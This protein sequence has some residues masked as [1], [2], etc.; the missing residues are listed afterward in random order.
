VPAE[1]IAGYLKLPVFA[2]VAARLA[3]LLMW[4]PVL[5]AMAIPAR[6]RAL[7]ILGL[8]AMITPL[9]HLPA[10]APDTPLGVLLALG[11]E[12]LLGGLLGLLTAAC[13]VGLEV[14]GQLVAQEAGLAFGQLVDPN[15]EQEQTVVGVFQVQF[16]V[17]VYLVIGGHRALLAACLDTFESIPLLAT[18]A[19]GAAG[20][21][22]LCRVLDQSG[23]V[24]LRVTAP[25]LLALFLV[26]L[27]LGFIS[28]TLP[29]LNIIAVGFSVK[30][31]VAFLV[32]AAAL[33]SATGAWLTALEHVYLWLGELIGPG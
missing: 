8:A 3:G 23:Q 9:V 2:L 1:L 16:A 17:V 13:F 5:G 15:T 6:L 29:Q 26:N 30:S 4:Q 21:E 27:A 28:R 14:G 24:A 32:L 22:L 31:L 11:G 20:S 12:V 25:A 7:L 19:T 10:D 33:P 18:V